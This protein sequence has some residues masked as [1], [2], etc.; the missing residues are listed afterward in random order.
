MSGATPCR[1]RIAVSAAPAGMVMRILLAVLALVVLADAGAADLRLRVT[2]NDGWRYADGPIAGAQAPEFD[3]DGWTRVHLPHT[4]NAD[5]AMAKGGAYRRG[6]GW[7]RR[8][9]DLD[10]GLEGRRLFLYF[11]GANQVAELF[12]N[13]TAVGTHVGGYTAFAFEITGQV[14]FDA[15]NVLAV[16]VDNAH[17]PDIPPL[18]ADFTF[19]GG[20]YRDV[21]LIATDPVHVDVLDHAAPGLY[22]DT[23]ELSAERAT[24]RVRGAVVNRS[25]SGQRLELVLRVTD[26]DG[27]E[28]ATFHSRLDVTAGGRAPFEA[29]SGPIA[30]PRLWSPDRPALYR[31]ATEV[32]S[33]REPR[34]RVEVPLGFR[35]FRFD[36][37]EGFFLNGERLALHGSNRHQDLAGHGNALSDAAHRRDVE[38]VKDTGFNFLRLAHYPQ[39]PAVLAATDALGLVVWEEIPVVNRVSLSETFADLAERM[40]V[41]M[42]RQHSN[43]P[44]I[45]MWGYMN[46]A[47]QQRPTPTPEGYVQGLVALARRLEARAR[48]EDPGRATATAI[49]LHEI[50]DGSG[51][52]DVPQ[53][54]GLNLYFGWY[55]RDLDAWGPFLDDLHAR[56]PGRPL[57]I[58][59]YGAGSDERVH[60]LAPRAF[61]FSV[62]HQQRFH[63]SAFAALRARP[64]VAGT[65]V[66]N[67]FDFASAGRQ[68]TKAALNQKGLYFHDH[69]PK[70]IAHY[71]RAVLRAEPVLHIAA[72]EWTTRAGSR[73]GDA[74]QPIVVYSNLDA[75]EL[76]VNGKSQ[77]RVRPEN[78]TARWTVRLRDGDNRIEA[79]GIRDADEL[80]DGLT[81]RYHDRSGL[82]AS[83]P[84][85]AREIAVNAGGPYHVIGDGDLVWEP[86]RPYDA[87]GW[88]H[89]GGRELRTH[90]SLRGT[91]LDPLL[92][93]TRVGATAYRFDVPD[94][95][96]E[97]RLGFVETEHNEPG[98]RIIDVTVNGI[99]FVTG[100]DLVAEFGP[101][102]AVERGVRVRA[103]E[104]KGI[105]VR[106]AAPTGETTIS[107]LH[108]R[109]Q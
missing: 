18:N 67:Q 16:R 107:S 44:S 98:R 46:E 24:V 75:V 17:D 30:K 91:R 48:A 49:S 23:P 51:L 60:A 29:T 37:Q 77:G 74:E 82:F 78:A 25:P 14:R 73:A 99:A 80:R 68:D 62:E 28:V 47:L 53:I 72:R 88:G 76:W 81:I 41:E 61:D 100:L 50:A 12:V 11:E 105:V 89:L 71:Y 63:E 64:Y 26:P 106:L 2:L 8:T 1:G 21:W 58:S 10:P 13:G 15:P 85:D 97:L 90:R 87:G 36:A 56:H 101:F 6:E 7:Y 103:V 20:I 34:D 3:D 4:W 39:D 55:Y 33:G 79:H 38:R 83:Q 35:W 66:W 93:T 108:L 70:D 22:V 27:R 40:L 94:A 9:L 45:L 109:R 69:Q 57:L 104:G 31:V 92:Q 43:H 19:F 54:L 52:Q 5:D 59:E 42:I 96:Y 65:A 84:S 32:R 86:D 102:V 95:E